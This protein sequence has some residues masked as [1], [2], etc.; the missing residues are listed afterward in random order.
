[1]QISARIMHR[2]GAMLRALAGAAAGLLV[3]LLG[4]EALLRLA[5]PDDLRP[6]L[7]AQSG[8]VGP[9]APDPVLGA[10][11]RSY[12]TFAQDYAQR[13]RQLA[14]EN[15]GRPVW[16]MFGNSFLQARGMLG[17]TAQLALPDHQMF[18]LKRN[19]PYY[20]RV[21]QLRL[22]LDHG[23]RPERVV[24][25][26][27]PIDMLGIALD[28]S[29]SVEVTPGGAIG[30]RIHGP[31]VLI[32]LLASSRLALTAWTRSGRHRLLPGYR[33][34]DVLET[35]P[36]LVTD[37]LDKLF[38]EV[39]STAARHRV[40][41]TLVFIPNREQVFGDGRTAPEDAYRAVAQRFGMDFLDTSPAFAAESDKSGLF[42]ADG[43]FSER[44]NQVLLAALLAHLDLA[45]QT[46]G[47]AR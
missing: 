33:G 26:V 23:L 21:A 19:E 25:F 5:P 44:G 41:V 16:A 3:L 45:D 6:F 28:P 14:E 31:D 7:G 1:M 38:G 27:L 10:G 2:R 15:A 17:D 42:I 20:L 35:P 30:Q 29:T 37:E 13:L 43:H 4:G 36:A 12:E 22:L 39:A 9:Y 18:F 47:P 40:P 8:L 32:R 11:Y 46:A 34:E 24:F